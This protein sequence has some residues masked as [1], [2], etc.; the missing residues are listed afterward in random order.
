MAFPASSWARSR[1]ESSW[2]SGEPWR[3]RGELW[4]AFASCAGARNER[5]AYGVGLIPRQAAGIDR[6]GRATVGW[7]RALK[8][9]EALQPQQRGKPIHQGVVIRGVELGRTSLPLARELEGDLEGGLRSPARGAV[10]GPAQEFIAEDAEGAVHRHGLPATA[11]GAETGARANSRRMLA[12]RR[13]GTGRP[14]SEG[15]YG[16]AKTL[17]YL[18]N[19]RF[20]CENQSETV[21]SNSRGG[22]VTRRKPRSQWTTT[23]SWSRSVRSLCGLI[24]CS[25]VSE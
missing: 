2:A 13:A 7:P 15:G 4:L 19:D 12:S 3:K 17:V 1:R 21:P 20:H 14:C 16:M 25:S 8:D 10:S 22:R 5:V 9:V 24:L 23:H 6:A 18:Q 11:A